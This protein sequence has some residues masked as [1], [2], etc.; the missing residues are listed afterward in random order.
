MNILRRWSAPLLIA[1]LLAACATIIG[2]RQVDLPQ[3]RLQQG[4]DHRFPLHHRAL[5]VFD[6][7]LNHPQLNIIAENDRV[8][9]T[10]DAN[11]SPLLARQSWHGTMTLSGRLTVDRLRNA[12]YLSD[13]HVDRF[14]IDGMDEGRQ[15]QIAGVAN[16][17]GEK[18][19]KDAPIYTFHQDE[20]R[21]AG[22]QFALTRISTR[23]GGLVATI[24]P[25]Q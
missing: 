11:V 2:P 15:H 10:L 3:D 4:L 17:L 13:A 1:S 16:L 14:I 21:Y 7:E 18:V 6:I 22:V 24:E 25:A 23:P 5:G 19:M 12:I 20:L 8:A 9:L